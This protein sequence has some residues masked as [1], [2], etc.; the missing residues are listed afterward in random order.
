MTT[1]ELDRHSGESSAAET[2]VSGWRFDQL[3]R[4]GYRED[5]AR[6]L[7]HRADIDLHRALELVEGGCPPDLAFEILR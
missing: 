7:A 6:E 1:R 3:K 4:A 2:Q 5:A